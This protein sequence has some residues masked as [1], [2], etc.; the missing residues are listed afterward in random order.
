MGIQ[1]SKDFYEKEAPSYDSRRWQTSVGQFVYSSQMEIFKS[2]ANEVRNKKVLDIAAGTGRF[3]KVL[4]DKNNSVTALDISGPMLEQLRNLLKDHPNKDNLTVLL[5]DARNI[6]IKTASIDTVVMIN[7]LSHIPEHT[8]VFAEVSRIL[9]P[10][11][12]FIFN[13]PNYLSLYLPFG[14]YVNLRKKSVTRDVYTRWYSFSEISRTLS[15]LNMEI[16]DLRGQLHIPTSSPPIIVTIIK[17]IDRQLRSG[18]RARL[19]PILF[20][21]VRKRGVGSWRANKPPE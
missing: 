3:T 13:V 6:E 1:G 18:F 20:F 11:G 2:F 5:G 19:A 17:R 10:D 14:L 12:F 15:S 7:A 9:K 4:L 8:K 16:E 21:K